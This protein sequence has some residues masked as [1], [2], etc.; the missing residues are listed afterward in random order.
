MLKFNKNR[1]KYLLLFYSLL[2]EKA[3]KLKTYLCTKNGWNIKF[4]VWASISGFW[5]ESSWLDRWLMT[6]SHDDAILLSRLHVHYVLVDHALD[7]FLQLCR[8][9]E[10]NNKNK[11]S[12]HFQCPKLLVNLKNL[13]FLIRKVLKHDFNYATSITKVLKFILNF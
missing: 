12:L 11:K 10:N 4:V 1:N 13:F 9:V 2:L 8:S 5:I 3:K 6:S 7:V